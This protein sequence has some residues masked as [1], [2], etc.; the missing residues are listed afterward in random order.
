MSHS[1][2]FPSSG[3]KSPFSLRQRRPRRDVDNCICLKGR[4]GIDGIVKCFCEKDKGIKC[5]YCQ[6][7]EHLKCYCETA[8]SECICE[9]FCSHQCICF[10]HGDLPISAQD[11]EFKIELI[12]TILIEDFNGVNDY[13]DVKTITCS[14]NSL[15]D[16]C[17]CFCHN[18][19]KNKTP[20]C[21]CN[22]VGCQDD[23]KC[24]CHPQVSEPSCACNP[25]G[26]QDDCK[27]VCHPQVSA[28]SCACNP[29]GCQDDCK[30]VCHPQVSGPSC[31]CNIECP[32]GCKCLVEC[33]AG[34]Y[35]LNACGC[36]LQCKK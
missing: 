12:K 36:H 9:N 28:P 3:H 24:V 35:C 33:K 7:T 18:E 26:C 13:L 2:V 8:S 5:K 1:H 25:V 19:E 31:T 27:C 17:N 32:I 16:G 10:C 14:C 11:N 6:A 21:A 20:S 23:C 15:C 4:K 22:P 30:C 34:I 29:V